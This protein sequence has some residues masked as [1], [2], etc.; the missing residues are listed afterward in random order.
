MNNKLQNQTQAKK[1]FFQCIRKKIAHKIF[2]RHHIA[3]KTLEVVHRLKKK[4]KERF[5]AK[6]RLRR[7]TI[8]AS[9]DEDEEEEGCSSRKCTAEEMKT[10]NCADRST[11][12]NVW[13]SRG[14]GATAE[15]K[16]RFLGTPTF[17][18]P[19]NSVG[20]MGDTLFSRVSNQTS[21]L[22]RNRFIHSFVTIAMYH[23]TIN[24]TIHKFYVHGWKGA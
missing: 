1:P 8:V 9:E 20:V 6:K 13:R 21:R 14:R 7:H 18:L 19:T 10:L 22:R 4:K 23:N 15:K 16:K 24:V 17:A 3:E 12:G 5:S 11:P 2:L